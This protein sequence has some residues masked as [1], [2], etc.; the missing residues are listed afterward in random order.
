MN[1]KY[2]LW[3]H[4]STLLLSPV[5]CAG[6]TGKPQAK[7]SPVKLAPPFHGSQEQA[8]V[9]EAEVTGPHTETSEASDSLLQGLVPAI[10][11]TF[12]PS[13]CWPPGPW[14]W[15]AFLGFS[16]V[17]ETK[18]YCFIHSKRVWPDS[19]F[20]VHSHSGNAGFY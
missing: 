5:M 9:R 20:Q 8:G 13:H 2:W 16:W 15:L 1:L 11:T 4:K 6:R 7:A 10:S 18:S 3:L 17:L 19:N 12:L 14:S